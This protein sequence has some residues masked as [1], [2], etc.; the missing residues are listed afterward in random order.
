M[1]NQKIAKKTVLTDA[2]GSPEGVQWIW[3]DGKTTAV[4][5]ADIPEK[6]QPYFLANGI[7]QKFGDGY[8]KVDSVA[9]ARGLWEAL[10]AQ[11]LDDGI[12]ARRGGRAPGASLEVLAEAVLRVMADNPATA[13]RIPEKEAVLAKLAA[14]TPEEMKTFK[15]KWPSIELEVKKIEIE[16]KEAA[17]AN[18]AEE[19][20][21][22]DDLGDMFA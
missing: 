3:A 1:A 20:D 14:M 19:D 10:V 22:M 16:R 21:D 13:D 6:M 7:A 8:S 4:M 15:A 17:L 5:F 2:L 18:K 11:V 9:E 12:W